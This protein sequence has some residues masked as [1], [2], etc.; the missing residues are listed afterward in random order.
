MQISDNQLDIIE[1]IY[2]VLIDDISS[3]EFKAELARY[4]YNTSFYWFC[5]LEWLVMRWQIVYAKHKF[6]LPKRN[7]KYQY[8]II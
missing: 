7:K 6:D 5:Y 8:I 3:Y 2:L 1:A 4:I